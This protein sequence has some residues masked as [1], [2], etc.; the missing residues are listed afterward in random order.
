M[1][2]VLITGANGEIGHGLI[3]RLA[4][5]AG[6][7]IVALDLNTADGRS[8]QEENVTRSIVGDITD[9]SGSGKPRRPTMT[10]MSSSTWPRSSPPSRSACPS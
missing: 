2:T 3:T 9:G 4:E 7:R 8:L 1:R 10:S 6:N 5:S